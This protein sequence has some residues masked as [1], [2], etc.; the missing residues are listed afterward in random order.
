MTNAN[1]KDKQ[2]C[3]SYQIYYLIFNKDYTHKLKIECLY[4]LYYIEETLSE[5]G[6]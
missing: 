4:G 2:E 1:K 6:S 5:I 3:L